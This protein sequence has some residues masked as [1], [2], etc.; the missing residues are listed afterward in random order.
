MWSSFEKREDA[1]KKTTADNF[2][3][4]ERFTASMRLHEFFRDHNMQTV[5]MDFGQEWL[6]EITD[7]EIDSGIMQRLEEKTRMF[8]GSMG[9]WKVY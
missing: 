5:V 7:Q 1:W 3:R 6:V 8:L 4:L 2:D 9:T